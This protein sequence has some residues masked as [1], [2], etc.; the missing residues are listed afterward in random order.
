[1]GEAIARRGGP[2]YLWPLHPWLLYSRAAGQADLHTGAPYRC[3]A[4]TARQFSDRGPIKLRLVRR[5]VPRSVALVKAGLSQSEDRD[6]NEVGC[7]A[8]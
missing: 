6:H 8:N 7:H 5:C 2:I 1:M 4:K 3:T